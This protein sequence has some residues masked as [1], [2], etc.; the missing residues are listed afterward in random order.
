MK[1]VWETPKTVVQR[2]EPNE[3]VAAC[4]TGTIQCIYPGRSPEQY[5][6][7]IDTYTD[8]FNMKHGICGEDAV[9]HFDDSTGTGYE[10]DHGVTD[11]NRPIYNIK[12]YTLEVGT[13]YNVTWTSNSGGPEYHHVGRLTITNIDD[14]RPN[15]S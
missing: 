3:Y 2:F 10:T 14:S 6:D 12:G 15:H 4:V 1:K 9:I 8:Q 7:G 13:H 11:Y 5:D